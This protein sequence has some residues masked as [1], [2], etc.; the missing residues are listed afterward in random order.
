MSARPPDYVTI[1]HPVYTDDECLPV[2]LPR[3]TPERAAM[4]VQIEASGTVSGG[5]MQ[6][7]GERASV[8]QHG[9]EHARSSP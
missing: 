5:H 8:L 3:H 1:R 4:A 6:Y 7:A 2:T 9:D